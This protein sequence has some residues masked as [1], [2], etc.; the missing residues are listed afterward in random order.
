[1]VPAGPPGLDD[2]ARHVPTRPS[3]E[4]VPCPTHPS[5]GRRVRRPSPWRWRLLLLG[6]VLST[7]GACLVPARWARAEVVHQQGYEATVLGWTSWYGSYS[8]AGLG[9]AWC[10]D[11][12]LRAPDAASATP[13]RARRRARHHAHGHGLARG[14]HGPAPSRLDAAAIMLVLHDLVGAAYPGGRLDLRHLTPAQLA[15]FDGQEAALLDRARALEADA[16]AHG[17]LVGPLRLRVRLPARL[18]PNERG[19]AVAQVSDQ[20]GHPLGG[21]AVTFHGD[22]SG[23]SP[24]TVVTDGGGAPRSPSPG[25]SSVVR[26]AVTATVPDLALHVFGPSGAPAQRVVVPAQLALRADASLAPVPAVVRLLKVGDRTPAVGVAGARFTLRRSAAA[27]RARSSPTGHRRRRATCPVTLVPGAYLVEETA[28]P[29]GY[30]GAGPWTVH[31]IGGTTR[32]IRLADPVARSTLRLQKV[33]AQTGRPL[34]GAVLQLR[35]D[36][37]ANG[38]FETAL[39][40]V[41]TTS[42]PIDLG[43]LLPGRYQLVEL[44][45]PAGYL[46]F[47]PQV[48][49]L[50]PGASVVVRLADPRAPP[51]TIT[52]APPPPPRPPPPRS[53]RPP[54]PPPPSSRPRARRPP[55]RPCLPRPWRRPRP[56]PPRRPRCPRRPS[57]PA[58]AATP[59]VWGCSGRASSAWARASSSPSGGVPEAAGALAR[60]RVAQSPR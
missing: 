55:A 27:A 51:T 50:A 56:R 16:L 15:G 44:R 18:L 52:T 33:D 13:P 29:P 30:R 26:V 37:D 54:P 47:P 7:V 20:V 45:A 24:T 49:A 39:P 9:Q 53:R 1:M 22:L 42:A 5:V 58:P 23:H 43:N 31:L 25:H 17:N 10:I 32:T 57:C 19:A 46:R 8:L 14:H 2:A 12:G 34:A 4:A 6:V 21:V 36:R 41:T 48:V 11:H 60:L 28:P 35:A 38:T 3:G 59:P 40:P